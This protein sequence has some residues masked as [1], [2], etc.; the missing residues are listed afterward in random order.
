[1]N[2]EW[3]GVFGGWPPPVLDPAGPAAAPVATMTLIL[4][5]MG[6]AVSLMVIVAVAFAMKRAS[7]AK[8]WLARELVVLLGGLALPVVVLTALLA[9]GLTLTTRLIEPAPED[10]LRIR[11][12]GEQWWWRITYYDRERVLFETA[13]EFAIPVGAP[14]LL[15]LRSVDVIH[16][17]WVPRLGGKLDLIPGRTN[18]LRLQADRPGLYGGQC[19]EYCGGA[20]AWMKFTVRAMPAEDFDAWLAHNAADAAVPSTPGQNEGAA[21]FIEQGCGECHAVRGL[22]GGVLGPDLTHIAARETLAAGL[23]PMNQ[24]ALE[25]WIAESQALKPGNRM[26]SYDTLNQGDLE[27][28]SAY[29]AGLE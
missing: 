25:R 18:V 22:S 10:A 13:N 29:L 23:L 1:M 15:E 16:S 12:V 14:V 9:Y 4:F 5:G 17:F 11:I 26:P 7:A 8:D 28:L 27:A 3:T 21:L 24:A 6:L 20:H 19:A 2:G